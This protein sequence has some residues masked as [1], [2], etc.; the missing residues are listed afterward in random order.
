MKYVPVILLVVLCGLI[1]LA[2]AVVFQRRV[3]QADASGKAS[4]STGRDEAAL[5]WWLIPLCMVCV[6]VLSL[7]V[8]VALAFEAIE[9]NQRKVLLGQMGFVA[10][11]VGLGT[12]LVWRK[13][14][15]RSID[16]LQGRR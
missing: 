3:R 7:L 14:R 11:C 6:A 16:S 5:L 8:P 1:F 4:T 9:Q 2:M 10:L 12:L 13:G 15:A